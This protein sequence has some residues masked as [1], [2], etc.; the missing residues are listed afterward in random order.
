MTVKVGDRVGA[1]CGRRKDG[2][3]DFYGYGT[4]AGEHVPVGAVGFIADAII[5]TG[6]KN[7]R[8]DLDDGAVV[9]GCECW[10]M[11]EDKAK[12]LL[13]SEKVNMVKIADKR[14]EILE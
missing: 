5:G 6:I 14:R 3:V 7:P 13:S 8:I 12:K 2:V 10:W 1:I 11:S 4:Y 9:W